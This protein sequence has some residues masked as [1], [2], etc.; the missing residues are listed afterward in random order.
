M[1]TKLDMTEIDYMEMF[2]SLIS[3]IE[4][5]KTLSLSLI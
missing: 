3:I 1:E 2:G 4:T 5:Q